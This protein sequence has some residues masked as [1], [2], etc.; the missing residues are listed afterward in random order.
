MQLIDFLSILIFTIGLL[1]KKEK[2]SEAMLSK[3]PI[4]SFK[5]VSMAYEG[6]PNI[7][8]N[9]SFDLEPGSYHFLTGASGAGKST[10]IR[11]MDLGHRN[12]HGQIKLFGRDISQ[13]KPYEVPYFR[14]K[15]GVVFQNFNLL[16]HLSAL[17]NVSLPLRVRGMNSKECRARAID[18]LNWVDLQDKH[19]VMPC[20][21]SGGEK[22]R[23][24]IARAVVGRPQLLLADE[25]TGSVDDAMAVKLLYL[26]EALHR[27]GTTIVLATHNTDLTGEFPHNEISLENRGLRII[28]RDEIERVVA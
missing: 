1:L 10:F 26:F 9:I 12:F 19:D 5:N 11:L 21:L 15:I 24:A 6:C 13:I 14:Q 25:P 27:M 22:Q 28:K 2:S 4:V 7:F 3:E 16:D 23:V 20:Q 17:D 8:D 18:I